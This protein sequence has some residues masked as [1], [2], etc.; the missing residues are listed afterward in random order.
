MLPVP[1]VISSDASSVL[2]ELVPGRHGQDSIEAGYGPEVMRAAGALLRTLQSVDAG[3]V[4]ELPGDGAVITHGDFGP[5]NLLFD[6]QH[7]IAAVLDWEFAHRGSPVE[8]LAWSEW[9]VRMHHPADLDAVG[10]LFAG[11]GTRPGWPVRHAAMLARCR[12]LLDRCAR[13]RQHEAVA[14]WADRLA[15]TTGW[16][17]TP[18]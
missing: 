2:M 3:T 15:A 4:A 10:E 7:R 17:E 11:Y 12:E 1:A 9:I 18:R 16:V 5:Q 8:D 6:E 14:M 13:E